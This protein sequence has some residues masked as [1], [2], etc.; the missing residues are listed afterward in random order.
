VPMTVMVPIPVLVRI[1]VVI[2]TAKV[3]RIIAT[4]VHRI[5]VVIGRSDRSVISFGPGN[6]LPPWR[7]RSLAI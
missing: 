1:I 5:R 6:E 4:V 2:V 3:A 7:V